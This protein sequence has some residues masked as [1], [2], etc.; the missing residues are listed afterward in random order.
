M[1]GSHRQKC[2]C[3][4]IG[5]CPSSLMPFQVCLFRGLFIEFC[6]CGSEVATEANAPW[7][8]NQQHIKLDQDRTLRYHKANV[9]CSSWACPQI[10]CHTPSDDVAWRSPK[11]NLKTKV[12]YKL[13]KCVKSDKPKSSNI[14][15]PFFPSDFSSVQCDSSPL[16]GMSQ[17]QDGGEKEGEGKKK[18]CLA[19]RC[20][21][22]GFTHQNMDNMVTEYDL[23]T[24]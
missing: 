24:Y 9:P 6:L 8:T 2:V 22:E 11:T 20:G 3:D 17:S 21:E 18:S 5:V 19:V 12:I 4:T 15:V 14:L 7:S 23:L 13:Q 1:W 16:P 10:S